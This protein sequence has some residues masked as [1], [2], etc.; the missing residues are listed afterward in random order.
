[1]K[2]MKCK[3]RGDKGALPKN[4]GHFFKNCKEQQSI[5]KVE[6]QIYKVHPACVGTE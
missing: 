6:K 4:A 2:R 5:C 1:M 3:G